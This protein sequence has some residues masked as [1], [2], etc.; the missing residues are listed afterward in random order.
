MSNAHAQR[1]R[2]RYRRGE[3]SIRDLQKETGRA[4]E[5]VRRIV[6]GTSYRDD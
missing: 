6:N 4:Y 3:A 5:T 2:R 1:L